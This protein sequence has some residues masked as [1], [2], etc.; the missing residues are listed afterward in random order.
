MVL[1]ELP[2][3]QP[4]SKYFM[5]ERTMNKKPMLVVMFGIIGALVVSAFSLVA[6][7]NNNNK[8]GLQRGREADAA[9]YTAMAESYAAQDGAGLQRGREADAAR[10]TAMAVSYAA[11]DGAGLQRGRE[12]DAARYTAMAESYAAQDGAGLQRGREADAARYTAMARNYQAQNSQV[13]VQ[14]PAFHYGPPGR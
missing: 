10:Y 9:R 4:Y 1:P 13:L 7:N 2:K 3:S 6:I 8:A 14:V 12:A 11:Q 5:K